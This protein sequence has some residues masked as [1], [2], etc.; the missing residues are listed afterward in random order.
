MGP[1]IILLERLI[2]VLAVFLFINKMEDENMGDLRAFLAQNAAQD[3]SVMYIASKRF[4]QDGKPVEWE[5]QSITSEEDEQIR[6]SCTK[7][8][9]VTGKKGQYTQELDAERYLGL[10]ATKCIIYPNLN[11]TELQ[12]S[13]KVMGADAVL[14]KML[15]PGEYQELLKKI[16]EINGFNI[17]MDEMVEEAKN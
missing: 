16:Q 11:A 7:K 2:F 4:A 14:K 1:E 10:L 8:V 9:P 13:Y 5:L 15:K 3:R 6:K 12:D 17:D